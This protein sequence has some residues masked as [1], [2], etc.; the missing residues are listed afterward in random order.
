MAALEP[1]DMTAGDIRL[2][3]W[4]PSDADEVY[5]ACQDPG[6]QRWTLV[7]SPYTRA[8][9]E[10][11]VGRTAPAGW[12]D[13]T[14]AQFAVLDAATARLL[15][16]VGLVSVG[17]DGLAEIGY[18]CAAEARGRGVATRA[19]RVL[20]RWALSVVGVERLEWR[21]EVGNPASRRVAEKAGFTVEGRLRRALVRRDGS[22]ADC[23]IGSLLPGDAAH[24]DTI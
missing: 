5:R 18:W 20:A 15:A 16:S 2:R 14:A 10:E 1:V 9:A 19:T 8:D 12:A 4:V 6:I 17:P 23:W 24:L 7:P 21:A 11:F 3:P 13:G 22:R